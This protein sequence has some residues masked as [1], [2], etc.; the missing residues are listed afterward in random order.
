MQKL[1]NPAQRQLQ[2]NNVLLIQYFEKVIEKFPASVHVV[3]SL[4]LTAE[5][6]FL[7]GQ[8][9]AC[10]SVVEIMME[11]FPESDLTGFILM[12]MAQI[13]NMR[14]ETEQAIEVYRTIIRQFQHNG[15]K[16]QANAALKELEQNEN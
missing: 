1:C 9:P 12:R 14:G 7:L 10:L 13:Y 16:A 4:F 3:E 11:Q 15:L 5:S 2:V 8:Y 6:Y